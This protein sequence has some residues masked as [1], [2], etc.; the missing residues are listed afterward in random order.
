MAC[1]RKEEKQQAG[2]IFSALAFYLLIS[3]GFLLGAAASPSGEPAGPPRAT[4]VWNARLLLQPKD[5]EGLL[6]FCRSHRIRTLYLYAYDVSSPMD[7]VYRDFNR[8]AHRVGLTVHALG[9]DP[10]WGQPRY[11][12]VSLSWVEAIRKFNA[13]AAKE[14][15]FDGVHTDVEV[16]LLSKSWK[17]QPAALLGGYLELHAKIARMLQGDREPMLLAADIPFW[18][19]DD[20]AWRILWHGQIKPPSYHMIDTADT[21]TVMAYRNAADGDNGTIRLVSLE[22]D[23]ADRIGKKVVIGQETQENLFP[24]YITFGG[25]SCETMEGELKKAFAVLGRRPS[26]GGFAIHHYESYRKLCGD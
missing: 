25:S 7:K 13:Q 1:N 11:H 19:D 12:S 21:V 16:Y 26:F 23:Y 14:E 22:M 6:D 18:F 15:R 5:Q 9:G 17:E 4:W 20:P 10:R 3:C 8:R 2:R 24:P